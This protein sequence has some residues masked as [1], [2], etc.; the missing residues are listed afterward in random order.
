MVVLPL[1]TPIVRELVDKY[2]AVLA[3]AFVAK[4]LICP[5]CAMALAYKTPMLALT[6]FV[7]VM[8]KFPAMPTPP[9]TCKAPVVVLVE[10]AL[11]NT[12]AVL[13]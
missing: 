1:V 6:S 13:A 4:L 12:T 9:A 10:V 11:D 8:Y 7:L 2:A 3:L 5:C